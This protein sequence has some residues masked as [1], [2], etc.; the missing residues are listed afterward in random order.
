MPRCCRPDAAEF[1]SCYASV[2]S[3]GRDPNNLKQAVAKMEARMIQ[4]CFTAWCPRCQQV[5][6]LAPDLEE[7]PT[8][9]AHHVHKLRL[10][11]NLRDEI[12]M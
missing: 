6:L 5:Y 2:L 4:P 1:L 7:F 10:W 8:P 12:E 11:E 3:Y 9:S